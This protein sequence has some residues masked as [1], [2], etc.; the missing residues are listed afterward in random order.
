MSLDGGLI[1]GGLLQVQTIAF[2]LDAAATLGSAGSVAATLRLNGPTADNPFKDLLAV[3]G[4]GNLTIRPFT[5]GTAAL[6]IELNSSGSFRVANSNVMLGIE[7]V[8]SQRGGPRS[9]TKVGLGTLSLTA[10]NTFTG[11]LNTSMGATVIGGSSGAVAS[12]MLTINGSA[13]LRL[14]NSTAINANRVLDTATVAL[15]GGTIEYI[16][17]ASGASETAGSLRITSGAS[18]VNMTGDGANTLTFTGLTMLTGA[19]VTFNGID[20]D[21]KI[22][23]SLQAAGALPAGAY[24]KASSVSEFAVYDAAAGI[25]AMTGGGTVADY[26]DASTALIVNRVNRPTATFSATTNTIN[27]LRLGNFSVN[28]TA[29]LTLNPTAGTRT[30]ILKTGTA[31]STISS[32][33]A[34]GSATTE[35]VVNVDDAT[36]GTLT[37]SGAVSG[38]AKGLTKTGEGTLV[39]SAANSYTGPTF[40]NQGTVRN[41]AGTRISGSSALTVFSGAKLDVQTFVQPV[42]SL[43][44]Q[45]GGSIAGTGAGQ[46]NLGGTLTYQA[47]QGAETEAVV[48]SILGLAANATA[49][50]RIFNIARGTADYDVTISGAMVNFTGGT[51]GIA[52]SGLGVLKLS[53][54]NTFTGTTL[55]QQG[56]LV[57][58]YTTQNNN[59]IANAALTLG[60]PTTV[61]TNVFQG[62][63]TKLILLGNNSTGATVQS[64]AGISLA[65]GSSNT[66]ALYPGSQDVTLHLNGID[67]QLGSTLNI[68]YGSTGAGIPSVTTTSTNVNGI[69]GAYAVVNGSDWAAISS[70]I[71]TYVSEYAGYQYDD[72]T[73]PAG[74][75]DVSV[76]PSTALAATTV[77]TLR[78]GTSATINLT[79]AGR[80]TLQGGGILVAPQVGA[81]TITISGSSLTGTIAA[82]GELI[83]H[84]YNTAAP[85]TISSI[86]A[87]QTTSANLTQLIKTGPGTLILNANNTFTGGLRIEEGTVKFAVNNTLASFTNNTASRAIFLAAGATLDMS[88]VATTNTF[89]FGALGAGNILLGDAGT[90]VNPDNGSSYT[91]THHLIGGANSVYNKQSVGTLTMGNDI[92][93]FEGTLIMSN[94]A[95]SVSTD[96][97]LGSPTATLKLNGNIAN[98][99]V[100]A[101]A[102]RIFVTAGF[103][104]SPTRSI[105]L[106]GPAGSM[107]ALNIS[108]NQTFT[109]NN[110]ISGTAGLFKTGTGAVILNASNT[111][112][113]PMQVVA[114]NV[115]IGG[116]AGSLTNSL[117]LTLNNLV[118]LTFDD[119]AAN[120][121]GSGARVQ[122]L[123]ST[124]ASISLLGN[125]GGTTEQLVTLSLAGGST[126]VSILPASGAAAGL[127]LTNTTD[128]L[129]VTGLANRATVLFRGNLL[130]SGATDAASIL[131]DAGIAAQLVGGGGEA[132][133]TSISILPYAVG[134]TTN[135]GPGSSFVT[136]DPT[137]GIRPLSTLAEYLHYDVATSVDNVLISADAELTGRTVNSILIDASQ[138]VLTLNGSGTLEVVSG[139]MLFVGNQ[140]TNLTGFSE[141]DFGSQSGTLWINNTAPLGVAFNSV[142]T[143]T[144][145]FAKAGTGILTLSAA[146][147]VTGL[148]SINGGVL[149]VGS[150]SALGAMPSLAVESGGT[151]DLSGSGLSSFTLDALVSTGY[152]GG[153]V[154]IGAKTLTVGAGGGSGTFSGNISG[155]GTLIKNGAGELV[156]N[157][158]N[159]FTGTVIINAGTI[160]IMR[161][162]SSVSGGV[163]LSAPVTVNPGATFHVDMSSNPTNASPYYTG[164]VQMHGGTLAVTNLNTALNSNT[165]ALNTLTLASGMN[166]WRSNGNTTIT[167][168]TS[169]SVTTLARS[170]RSTVLALSTNFGLRARFRMLGISAS[171]NSVDYVGGL[172]STGTKK[173]IVPYIVA[174]TS[175]TGGGADFINLNNASTS[176]TN[177]VTPLAAT[178][179]A[180]YAAAA[181]TD[182]VRISAVISPLIGTTIN[183]LKVDS[184]VAGYDLSGSGVLDITSGALL[185]VGNSAQ[186]IGG[187][188]ALTT[189]TSTPVVSEY[190]FHVAN[191][192]ATG[193]TWNVPLTAAANALTKSSPGRLTLGANNTYGGPTTINAGTLAVSTGNNLGDEQSLTNG[194]VFSGGTLAVTD[195]F[196]TARNALF[197]RAGGTIDVAPSTAFALSGTL[198]G[199]GGLTKIGT[200][201]LT[202]S[203]SAAYTGTTQVKQGGVYFTTGVDA[204]SGAIT[205]GGAGFP[206][207]LDVGSAAVIAAPITIAALGTLTGTGAIT[208]DLS[209]NSGGTISPG[210]MAVGTLNSATG[211]AV[212][213]AGG[214]T[215]SFQVDEVI[216]APGTNWDYLAGVGI[217]G[218][219]ATTADPFRI[220]LSGN[221]AGFLP[222]SVYEGSSGWNFAH[223]DSLNGAFSPAAF[224]VE[225]T[226]NF[227]LAA[228]TFYVSQSGNDLYI[229]YQV[230]AVPE[231]GSMLLVSIAGLLTWLHRR[232]RKQRAEAAAPESAQSISEP[233]I[234]P[235]AAS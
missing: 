26:A 222:S 171:T 191:T 83:I 3:T 77:N 69:L 197:H 76:A 155:S 5:G 1:S 24:V 146:S 139:A 6:G 58:D 40:I 166:I 195:S 119:A 164:F 79:L 230:A 74:N 137:Y 89:I 41:T 49:V 27:G 173:S 19:T 9:L 189:G 220:R 16:G 202:L 111:F 145:G 179:Y 10:A 140:A 138:A 147:A 169:V 56:A 91:F 174:D 53:G 34:L 124:G 165:V 210:D 104:T 101:Y 130:G 209:I 84:Q 61:T 159:S 31:A 151:F 96:Y 225:P 57:L 136:Y 131:I 94:G 185:F 55:L 227:G 133:S 208:A 45:G 7:S 158:V 109:V 150:P 11:A 228:G 126:T 177:V 134:D 78:F 20:A 224:V 235:I 200:G 60:G 170:Q 161:E 23:F 108:A 118:T 234:A 135:S 97:Q 129:D 152:G 125:A 217:L 144:A 123:I 117:G 204:A 187:F 121:A 35:L 102:A 214:G 212:T 172:A 149:R 112:A 29:T 30:G 51:H 103:A 105:V 188:S 70:L 167:D 88:N 18:N 75:V 95:I 207:S 15:N 85:L 215:F 132:G 98:T 90:Y 223:F 17:N 28:G 47:L 181:A 42:A 142:L 201:N 154:S 93:N 110:V 62:T 213:F 127:Q 211:K 190:I 36:T 43:T 232:R 22:I 180:A 182:N 73:V 37:L 194:L 120:F 206:A 157:D 221:A 86:I 12:T 87:D 192:S 219:S 196:S 205:I 199:E 48:S 68:V 14:D 229:N 116:A 160:H 32:L 113:G 115:A 183:S 175:Y 178:E 21:S 198:T 66:I 143:G 25:I 226:G 2:A 141:I 52:K 44:F 64:V 13:A 67:R 8:I 186:T 92:P 54:A 106:N 82:A 156:L 148:I 168:T 33:I 65:I 46:V 162:P 193:I 163:V 63:N 216:G 80:L 233:T 38:A 128:G 218:V 81:N 39:L 184:G 59:K 203:S 4:D 99:L 176:T 107:H 231:P 122:K 72:F 100:S 71:P 153:N 114:G 50:N